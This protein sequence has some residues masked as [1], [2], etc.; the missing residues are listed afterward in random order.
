MGILSAARS[1]GLD[2]I[3]VGEEEYDFALLRSTLELKDMKEFL[4]ILTGD[5]FRESVE[6][7]GGYDCTDSGRVIFVN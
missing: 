5:A 4:E 2:F 6:R 7:I 3:P 1:L